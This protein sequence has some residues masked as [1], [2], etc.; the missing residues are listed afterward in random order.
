MRS[1]QVPAF[2]EYRQAWSGRE[3]SSE[4]P[5]LLT[6]KV[7]IFTPC[8]VTAFTFLRSGQ[9]AL[10]PKLQVRRS[11]QARPGPAG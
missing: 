8:E 9:M 1:T 3:P 11:R 4:P 5:P 10:W 7:P 2:W 6:H